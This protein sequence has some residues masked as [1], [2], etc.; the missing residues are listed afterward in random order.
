MTPPDKENAMNYELGWNRLRQ[1]TRGC[2]AWLGEFTAHRSGRAGGYRTPSSNALANLLRGIMPWLAAGLAVMAAILLLTYATAT[3]LV[4]DAASTV[5]VRAN[6]AIAVQQV[7]VEYRKARARCQ[8]LPVGAKETCIVEAH[9]A[10]DRARTVANLTPDS[11]LVSLRASTVA[12]IDAGDHDSIVVEPACN[13]VMRGNA[14]L[15]E[16]QVKPGTSFALMPLRTNG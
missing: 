6:R 3:R 9:A 10:E 12:A 4:D 14:S 2:D 7:A 11:Y 15:C 8:R 16:I 5:R 13:I 1:F